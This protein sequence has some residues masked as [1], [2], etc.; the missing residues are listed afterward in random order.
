MDL[1]Q[2]RGALRGTGLCLPAADMSYSAARFSALSSIIAISA[3]FVACAQDGGHV[4]GGS[5]LAMD[6]QWLCRPVRCIRPIHSCHRSV[7]YYYTTNPFI[8]HTFPLR[9]VQ[10]HG[11]AGSFPPRLSL[12]T[13]HRLYLFSTYGPGQNANRYHT[14][15]AH[16]P[17]LPLAD[18]I[19]VRIQPMF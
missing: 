7:L 3:A 2:M 18:E 17:I 1:S 13:L 4:E 5:W 15:H 10:D 11:L 9:P 12:N 19:I 14:M 6:M 8:F 16:E